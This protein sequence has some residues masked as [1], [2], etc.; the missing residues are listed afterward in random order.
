MVI[1]NVKYLLCTL[2]NDSGIWQVPLNIILNKETAVTFTC[3]GSGCVHLTGYYKDEISADD[4]K[5]NQVTRKET[6]RCNPMYRLN[7]LDRTIQFI[8]EKAISYTENGWLVEKLRETEEKP[9]EMKQRDEKFV[10]KIA[11]LL[12]KTL[13]KNL[14]G[15]EA[16]KRQDW[17]EKIL[18]NNT[19]YKGVAAN[20][21]DN[22]GS[23]D[24]SDELSLWETE[25]Q[26]EF[27]IKDVICAVQMQDLKIG[28]GK[29]AQDGDYV[30]IYYVACVLRDSKRPKIDE[31]RDGRGLVVHLGNMTMLSG[32]ELGMMG[33]KVGGKCRLI[34]PPEMA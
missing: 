13:R 1:E 21:Y 16:E 23:D 15:Q 19:F 18:K 30:K 2:H 25:Q 7:C 26:I 8:K 17:K 33:M 32:L 6:D 29:A 20:L 4:W 11:Q 12:K 22:N 10:Q 9:Q 3:N 28:T 14:K 31:C 24:A 34:I 5:E 27:K